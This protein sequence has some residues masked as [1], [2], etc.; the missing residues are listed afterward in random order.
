[1]V[2]MAHADRVGEPFRAT[3]LIGQVIDVKMLGGITD[4]T[5]LIGGEGAKAL[6]EV[7]P[8]G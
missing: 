4:S 2:A 3:A 5:A 7:F 8:V 1:M 6:R